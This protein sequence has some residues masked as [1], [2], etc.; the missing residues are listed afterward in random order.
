[1]Q[2][3]WDTGATG[4]LIG[5][6]AAQK[7]GLIAVGSRN[8]THAGGSGIHPVY[9]VNV[10]LPNGVA[11]VGVQAVEFNPPVAFEFIIG[12]NII[13]EGDFTL[14]NLGGKTCLSFRIPSCH[15]VDYVSEANKLTF[16]G[17]SRNDPCPCGSGRKFKICHGKP[18]KRP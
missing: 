18:V 4:S 8:L 14:T 6:A 7:A 15:E 1:M 16:A 13:T 12:M 10:T 9:M 11:I 17:V 5:A 3:L 2:A